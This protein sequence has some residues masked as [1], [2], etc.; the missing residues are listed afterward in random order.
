MRLKKPDCERATSVS[1]EFL[2][3]EVREIFCQSFVDEMTY[4]GKR[5]IYRGCENGLH[6]WTAYP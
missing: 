5:A 4:N 6:H 3:G 1:S 2:E